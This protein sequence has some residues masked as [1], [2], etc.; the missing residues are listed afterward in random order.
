MTL[1][2]WTES[3]VPA[4][5]EACADEEIALWLDQI[6]QP[7]GRADARAY[8]RS[9]TLA[10]REGTNANFAVTDAGSG[11][12]LGSV[13]IRWEDWQQSIAEVG[14]WVK[15]EARGRGAATRALR[16]VSR[17]ALE[18]VG[19]ARLQLRADVDNRGS[20]VVAERAGFVREGVLRSSR[21][22]PRRRR[23]VDFVLYSLL[24][25]ELPLPPKGHSRLT[26][27]S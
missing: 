23:R 14:Y 10:W 27:P 25:G 2:P 16:L 22:N 18:T 1:R 5:A 13:G 15:R 9:S 12:A 6:P 3:D 21:Y 26:L 17:W 20:Q 8:V 7:Y 11:E 4:I 19:I 24:P